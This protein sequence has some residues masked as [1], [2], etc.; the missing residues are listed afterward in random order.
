MDTWTPDLRQS[1]Y[2]PQPH[3]GRDLNGYRRLLN[4]YDC[5]CPPEYNTRG[6]D[7]HHV[8]LTS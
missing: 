1:S 7:G 8:H 4:V 3:S 2:R 5:A 6:P